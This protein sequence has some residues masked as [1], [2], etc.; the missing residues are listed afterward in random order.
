MAGFDGKQQQLQRRLDCRLPSVPRS[1]LQLQRL[2]TSYP[3]SAC[4][5]PACLRHRIEEGS[6]VRHHHQRSVLQ[7]AQVALQPDDAWQVKVVCWLIQQ[8]Q[9]GL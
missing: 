3:P 1:T 9:V 2:P 6:V 4:I 8:Q 5:C 7:A